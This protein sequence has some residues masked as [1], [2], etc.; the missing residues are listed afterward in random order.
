[1]NLDDN[2]SNWA[3]AH[4]F[5]NM[6]THKSNGENNKAIKEEFEW[7]ER[8][9]SDSLHG[10]LLIKNSFFD[11]IKNNNKI[12]LAHATPN[13]H[14]ILDNNDIYPSG[15]CLVGSIYC[16][17]IF[18]EDGKLRVH[19]LGKYIFENEAPRFFNGKN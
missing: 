18:K 19:N 16:T 8:V 6:F 11:A 10:K 15:G 3:D 17:P 13:L 9:S 1:M 2:L 4:V 7:R 5:Y 12:Y 14:N